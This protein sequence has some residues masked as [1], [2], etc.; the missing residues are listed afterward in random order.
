MSLKALDQSL[1]LVEKTQTAIETGR[2]FENADSF[3]EFASDLGVIVASVA[4]GVIA[5]QVL[6]ARYLGAPLSKRQ[7]RV[8]L[9]R[10][11]VARAA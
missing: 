11:I 8:V 10:P 2:A 3:R 7:S 9:R 5:E 4:A 1:G 6:R